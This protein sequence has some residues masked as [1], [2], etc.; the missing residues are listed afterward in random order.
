MAIDEKLLVYDMLSF[1]LVFDFSRLSLLGRFNLMAKGRQVCVFSI[2]P[3]SFF[4]LF[5]GYTKIEKETKTRKCVNGQKRSNGFLN[6]SAELHHL[7]T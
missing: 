4:S 2:F 3:R 7:K 5:L 6:L 1:N